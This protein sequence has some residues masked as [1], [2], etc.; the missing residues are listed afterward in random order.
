MT[1]GCL[2]YRAWE[3]MK[4]VK[5]PGEGVIATVLEAAV[6]AASA[7]YMYRCSG[8]MDFLFVPLFFVFVISVFRGKSLWTRLFDNR[9]SAWL[10]RQSYAYFLNNV[11]TVYLYMHFFPESGIGAMIWF[12]VPLCLVISVITGNVLKKLT[13]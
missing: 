2:A 8:K 12:C 3:W 10:G 11:V 7:L 4:D 13:W 6:F 9:L 5:L 1:V